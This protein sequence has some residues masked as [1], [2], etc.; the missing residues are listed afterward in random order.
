MKDLTDNEKLYRVEQMLEEMREFKR[1]IDIV[2]HDIEV[3]TN[4]IKMVDSSIKQLNA[5][6]KAINRI[7]DFFEY[8]NSSK[9]DREQVHAILDNLTKELQIICSPKILN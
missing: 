2:Q 8:R 6:K 3:Q 5:Y 7:D 4:N 1:Q 9:S